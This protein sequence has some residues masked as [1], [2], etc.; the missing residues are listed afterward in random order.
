MP[1]K[2]VSMLSPLLVGSKAKRGLSATPPSPGTPT[3]APSTPTAAQLRSLSAIQQPAGLHDHVHK[4]NI[5]DRASPN[6]PMSAGLLSKKTSND[7]AASASSL[8]SSASTH[9]A[10]AAAPMAPDSPSQMSSPPAAATLQPH[11]TS[12][13]GNQTTPALDRLMHS[14]RHCS[15][16][17]S[18]RVEAGAPGNATA[19]LSLSPTVPPRMQ[20]ANWCL[21]D[22]TVS[23]KLYTGGWRLACR[24]GASVSPALACRGCSG[25]RYAGRGGTPG[26]GLTRSDR[27][28]HWPTA[29]PHS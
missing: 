8:S 9:A 17:P 5:G 29:N 19:L 22:Y 27:P 24:A 11:S 28:N 18:P 10:A 14:A 23:D 26:L 3:A 7:S 15:L 6:S 2:L 1:Q 4:M 16:P 13:H 21:D 12:G 20:R 25:S